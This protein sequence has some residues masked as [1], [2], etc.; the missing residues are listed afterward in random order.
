M[1]EF[2]GNEQL[3]RLRMH[4]A[5]RSG[6]LSEIIFVVVVV[7]WLNV[8][9]DVHEYKIERKWC[10]ERVANAFVFA[11][12][13]LMNVFVFVSSVRLQYFMC[14][15]T[16]HLHWRDGKW[17]KK[18]LL[19]WKAQTLFVVYVLTKPLKC[20]TFDAFGYAIGPANLQQLGSLD[21]THSISIDLRIH[22]IYNT[23]NCL[24]RFNEIESPLDVSQWT[25]TLSSWRYLHRI[26]VKRKI[27]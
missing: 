26:C 24:T 14:I 18:L 12:Y 1:D 21:A 4:H 20:N 2:N 3:I 22:N 25:C 19:S 23:D 13:Q 5:K 10:G 7:A 9:G 15:R 27:V 6:Q 17:M 8:C 16:V 11:S